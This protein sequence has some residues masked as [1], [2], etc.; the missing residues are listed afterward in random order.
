MKTTT[1]ILTF[2][3]AMTAMLAAGTTEPVITNNSCETMD[4]FDSS[5]QQSDLV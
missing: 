1:A 3:A 4:A 5:D 2:G